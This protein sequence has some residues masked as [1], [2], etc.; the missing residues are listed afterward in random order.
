MTRAGLK[1][2]CFL[3]L[4]SILLKVG[5]IEKWP[6]FAYLE[7][8]VPHLKFRV[9]RERVYMSVNETFR[10]VNTY[11][12]SDKTRVLCTERIIPVGIK[13]RTT[14]LQNYVAELKG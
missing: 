11:N 1:G 14:E 6:K 2:R 7:S 9:M 8:K 4:K 12:F 10:Y 3:E 13:N 5:Y